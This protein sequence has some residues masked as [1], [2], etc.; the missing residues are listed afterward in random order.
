M[1]RSEVIR[2]LEQAVGAE[3]VS[4][5]PNDL[6]AYSYD[7]QPEKGMADAMVLVSSVSEIAAVVK[8]AVRRK[9]PLVARG[10]GSGL[11]G[12]SVPE[13]GGIVLNLERMNR[14]LRIDVEDRIGYLQPGVITADFQKEAA[15]K[16][17][18]Y[19]PEPASSQHSTIGGN[20]A[21]SAGGLTCVK[22]GLTKQ[23]V[24]GLEFVTA[25]GEIVRTGVYSDR[26][27][28]FDVGVLMIGSEGTLGIVTEVAMRLIP[29]PEAKRTMLALFRT[30]D[31][32]VRASNAVLSSGVEPTVLEFMDKSCI[33]TVC[34]YAG[35][36]IPEG[37]GALLLIELDGDEEYLALAEARV[38]GVLG[39][40]NPVELKSAKNSEERDALWKL[41]KSISPAIARIAPLKF[42]EDICVPL[43]RIPEMC[44][45]V[46]E[47]GKRR[48]VR[49]VSFGHS[50]DGN[51]HI[52]FMTSL[53]RPEEVSRV[54]LAVE[55]LFREA[56]RMGGTLS[57]EHGI[58][59]MKR[60]YLRIAMDG[61]TIEFEKKVKRALDPVDVF[62]PGKIF[63]E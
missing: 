43:S 47:L 44:T 20:V 42:N 46:E 50:G 56:V 58:G 57:G 12:G 25:S 21:E 17:L 11:T 54:K 33:D 10:A 51:L 8:I 22:Y 19:P 35:V 27:T 52:N 53:K 62:N 49:V 30:L 39:K 37:T 16:G 4:A 15:R 61:A 48:D 6:I 13:R 2:E 3:N 26:E 29:L 32:T 1:I 28:P 59:M 60:P 23:F 34:E 40:L 31:E 38:M 9:I 36:E 14:I 45:F 63:P 41:R 55:E 24:A 18:F 5:D 7:S